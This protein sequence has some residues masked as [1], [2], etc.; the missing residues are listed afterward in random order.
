MREVQSEVSGACDSTLLVAVAGLHAP[1][2]SPH[3]PVFARYSR[4]DFFSL[5]YRQVK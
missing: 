5:Y 3:T 2:T 1:A 4:E